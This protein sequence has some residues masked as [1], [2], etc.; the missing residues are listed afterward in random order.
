[1]AG[2]VWE[3]TASYDQSYTH[4]DMQLI[5]QGRPDLTNVE[6]DLPLI[7]RGGGWEDRLERITE[8]VAAPAFEPRASTGFRC[9]V[10]R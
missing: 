4:Y 3:W 5:W 1:L 7:Q 2:N 10:S 8:R 9:A 6:G